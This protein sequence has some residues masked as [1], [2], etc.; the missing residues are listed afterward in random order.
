[1]E[2]YLVR[3]TQIPVSG[4]FGCMVLMFTD[5]EV[6]FISFCKTF[7]K[8]RYKVRSLFYCD[9]RIDRRNPNFCVITAEV[10]KNIQ[11]QQG[12]KKI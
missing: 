3:E 2:V 6:Y 7:A 5:N 4:A 10:K 1:M 12:N 11:K 9:Q 8:R